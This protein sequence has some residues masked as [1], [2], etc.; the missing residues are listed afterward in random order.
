VA[1]PNFRASL[2][3]HGAPRLTAAF[4]DILSITQTVEAT[5]NREFAAKNL[6]WTILGQS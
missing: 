2:N 6:I 4:H 3:F 1:I 5:C